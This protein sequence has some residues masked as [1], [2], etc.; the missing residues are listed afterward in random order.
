MGWVGGSRKFAWINAGRGNGMPL[1]D[2]LTGHYVC[3]PTAAIHSRVQVVIPAVSPADPVLGS[4]YKAYKE[5]IHRH[6]SGAAWCP[7]HGAG[8]LRPSLHSRAA[9]HVQAP[10]SVPLPCWSA[11][12]AVLPLWCSSTNIQCS[13]LHPHPKPTLQSGRA[14]LRTRP[15][16]T[17]RGAAPARSPSRKRQGGPC[18]TVLQQAGASVQAA[19]QPCCLP[20][21]CSKAHTSPC[22]AAAQVPGQNHREG[23]TRGKAASCS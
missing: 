11:S 23:V 3:R 9:M 15:C 20:L 6:H 22:C 1:L 5:K 12:T 4:K 16:G 19:L 17:L 2:G 7:W 18:S 21:A 13:L 8:V 10:D 14:R